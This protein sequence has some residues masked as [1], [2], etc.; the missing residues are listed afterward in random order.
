MVNL[1]LLNIKKRGQINPSTF[2]AFD[3]PH[4][5]ERNA[6]AENSTSINLNP[7]VCSKVSKF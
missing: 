3:C 7:S 4:K 6:R 5:D 1:L 2:K